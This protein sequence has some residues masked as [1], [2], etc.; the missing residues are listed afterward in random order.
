MLSLQTQL[1]FSLQYGSACSVWSAAGNQTYNQRVADN[2]CQM[3]VVNHM[4][5]D[6]IISLMS[7]EGLTTQGVHASFVLE[8]RL[9]RNAQ[10]V[11]TDRT[12]QAQKECC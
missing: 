2:R 12:C 1:Q 3:H 8:M 9:G 11:P 10:N 7:I 5:A 6:F 4:R